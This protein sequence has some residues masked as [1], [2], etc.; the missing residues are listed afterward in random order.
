MKS[1]TTFSA[2]GLVLL[3]SCSSF[4]RRDPNNTEN[5]TV[6]YGARDLKLLATGM[7]ESMV[8]APGLNYF[9]HESKGADPRIVVYMGGVDNRT[10]EF[11]DTQGITDSIKTA[12]LKSG[13]F[14]L[15]ASDQGQTE[16]GDQVRFQ[17]G[18]GRVNTETAKAF[19]RQVGA[20]VILYGRLISIEQEKGRSI[21]SL[22][23]KKEDVYYKFT[24]ECV[25]IE[26]GEIMWIDEQEVM[27]RGTKGL[28]G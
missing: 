18:T 17:Q 26:T 23:T 6:D 14:R 22:G 15:V 2:V 16:I 19:G 7:A 8:D 5:L 28:F 20:D 1:L 11:I 13:K 10:S 25:N 27:K 9:Q 12:L 21:Q 24:L 3:A 4:Q